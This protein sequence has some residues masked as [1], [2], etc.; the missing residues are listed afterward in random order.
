MLLDTCVVIDYLRGKGTAVAFFSHLQEK[1]TV[2]VITIAEVFVGFQSQRAENVAR[3][4]FD[5]CNVRVVSAAI[6]ES[7]GMHLRHFQSGHGME[8]ADALIAA[9]AEHHGLE[10]ATLNVKHFPMFKGLRAAY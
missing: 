8:L 4:F 2:S 9:T 5:S 1:P 7:A 3:E 10:L 6:A